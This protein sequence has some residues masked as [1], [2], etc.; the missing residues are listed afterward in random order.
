MIVFSSVSKSF[1]DK[2]TAIVDLNLEINEGDL[3]VITG[4]SGAGKTTLMKLL[5]REYLPTSGEITFENAPLSQLKNSEI[6]ALRRKIG[7][8]FQDYK[9]IEEMNVWENIALPLYISNKKD[10]EIESRVTDLLNLIGLAD[11]ALQFPRQL[12]GGEAQRVSIARALSVGPKI[13]FADEPTG[14]LDSEATIKIT[15]LLKKINELGTTLLFATH[16]QL[17]LDELGKGK[18]I[19][20]DKKEQSE[21]KKQNES[22]PEPVG[23]EKIDEEREKVK[24]KLDKLAKEETKK[25]ETKPKLSLADRLSFPKLKLKIGSKKIKNNDQKEKSKD[26]KEE[27][28]KNEST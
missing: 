27:K 13:I 6:P 4:P 20:L 2:Q 10:E 25:E 26:K 9:L 15:R 16:D 23:E 14:N 21:P 11:K 7:V 5:I 8:V 1:A 22:T 24:E 17:V 3:L 28:K 19:H 12:S 18:I